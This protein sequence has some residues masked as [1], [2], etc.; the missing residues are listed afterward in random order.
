VTVSTGNWKQLLFTACFL[1]AV[2]VAMIGW[3]I[4]LGWL[5]LNFARWLFF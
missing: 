2:A 4:A 3:L 1:V 5:A